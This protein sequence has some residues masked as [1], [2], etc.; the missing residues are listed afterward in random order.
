MQKF[1]AK[2]M[3][4]EEAYRD[5]STRGDGFAAEIFAFWQTSLHLCSETV[6]CLRLDFS[7][8]HNKK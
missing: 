8:A 4:L 6:C 2:N 3:K 5:T 7:R 1:L